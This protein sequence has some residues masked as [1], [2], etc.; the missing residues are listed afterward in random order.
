MNSERL[1][2]VRR[3]VALSP[4]INGQNL[5]DMLQA[6]RIW[7]SRH[8]EIVNAQNVFP[9][10]DGDTGTNMSQ[11]MAVACQALGDSQHAG[12]V[13][14]RVARGAFMGARGNSGVILSQIWRGFADVVG[15]HGEIDGK[16][17]AAGL[18]HSAETA[19]QSVTNPI[20]GTILT[21]IRAAADAATTAQDKPIINLLEQIVT[22]SRSVLAKTPDQLP[23]LKQTGVVDSGGQ[24]L[25]YLFEGM[26]KFLQG[27]L[28]LEDA[29]MPLHSTNALTAQALARPD[30]GR[31]ANPYDVQFLLHGENLNVTHIRDEIKGMGDSAVIVG[32]SHTIKVHVHVKDPGVPLSYAVTL[33]EMTDVVVENMQTQMQEIIADSHIMDAELK[34]DQI[35]LVAVALGDGLQSAF[36]RLGATI[37]IDGGQTNNPSITEIYDAVEQMHSERVIIL[38]NNKNILMAAE[39][40]STLSRKQVRV[41]PSQTIPQGICAMID[42]AADGVFEIVVERMKIAMEDV[43]SAEITLASR[44]ATIDSAEVV[45]GELIAIVNGK[46]QASGDQLFDVID[47]TLSHL[48]IEDCELLTL[49]YGVDV[50][51]RDAADVAQYIEQLYPEIEVELIRGG[52]PHYLYILGAE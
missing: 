51:M 22:A 9:V 14:M 17:F 44:N 11:T 32:D 50:R 42:Y 33:G 5:R 2:D 18:R 37:I 21:I 47:E 45:E 29:A 36:R 52:Q 28:L 13:A 16:L 1:G 20:E 4:S 41:V 15:E 3:E 38:P 12:E 26:L 40:A 23:I 39:A 19:Y 48:A 49:Y 30:D 35:G 6:G 27:E 24:G 43:S 7:L 46:L 8:K 25:V 34:T 31:I 10:P